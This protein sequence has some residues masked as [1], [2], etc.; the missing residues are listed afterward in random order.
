[1][2]TLDH[3]SRGLGVTLQE[4]EYMR[5]GAGWEGHALKLHSTA[6]L[7]LRVWYDEQPYKRGMSRGPRREE[8]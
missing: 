4:T 7:K 6:M 3:R 8:S 2:R 5:K 1:M